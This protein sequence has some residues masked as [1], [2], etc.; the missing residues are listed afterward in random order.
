MAAKGQ[1]PTRHITRWRS[2]RE[3]VREFIEGR[4]WNEARGSYVMRA[5]SDALD[6]GVLLASRRR[7]TDPRG[8][9]MNQTIDAILREL[10]ADGPLFY[11]YSGM[12]EQEN[13]FLACSFWMAEALALAGRLEEAAEIMDE[14]VSLGQDL[15]LYTEEMDPRTRE[16]RGNLPQA[17]THLALVSAAALFAEQTPS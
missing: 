5:G 12:Q 10:R 9:R 2:E 3:R 17:L 13:A 11:R 8:D 15:G 1:V 7:Y 4:L 16:M 6:C 14:M